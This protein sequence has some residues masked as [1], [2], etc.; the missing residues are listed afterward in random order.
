MIDQLLTN[1]RYKSESTDIDFKQAQ[2]RFSSASEEEKSEL[3]KDILAIANAWR[4]GTG[5]ILIGFRDQRPHPAE[6]VGIAVSDSIDD[7]KLQ[8]FVNSKVK[9]K[10]T[11]RYEEHLYEG[12]TVGIISIP[13]QKRP[14]YLANQFGKLRK[15]IVYVRRGS[16]TD[17]AEPGEVTQMGLSDAGHGQMQV[18]IRTLTRANEDLPDTFRLNHLTFTEKFTD[19]ES[20]RPTLNGFDVGFTSHRDNRHFYRECAE[21]VRVEESAVVMKL[22][23]QNI[24]GRQL[25]NAKLELTIE[26]LDGQS[27]E[28]IAG[29]DLPDIPRKHLD[30]LPRGNTLQGILNRKTHRLTVDGDG[31]QP[32]CNVLLGDLLPT[33]TGKSMDTI[34][35]VA[36]SPGRLKLRFK[37]LGAELPTPFELERIIETTGDVLPLNLDEF[38]VFVQERQARLK[39]QSRSAPP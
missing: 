5:Y 38:K 11:F 23:V 28:L 18:E 21:Y 9:P 31:R 15:N 6:V 2:Y 37:V 7:A 27:Y 4:D 22:E 33:E 12:K 24:S 20:P 8:Q 32:T 1:L 26:P 35:I 13:Q 14:F 25:S 16:S 10:L 39:A 36:R 17:E 29:Q 19:Y 34:A 3:L 30:L